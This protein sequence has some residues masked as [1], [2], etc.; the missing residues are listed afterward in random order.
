MLVLDDS[1]NSIN[2]NRKKKKLI[3][4]SFHQ[5]FGY[6]RP[7]F[8]FGLTNQNNL[9][10]CVL[11]SPMMMNNSF[12]IL[13]R[14]K[15]VWISEMINYEMKLV[16]RFQKEKKNQCLIKIVWNFSESIRI[17]RIFSGSFFFSNAIILQL[18]QRLLKFLDRI[19]GKNGMKS[20]IWNDYIISFQEIESNIS[21]ID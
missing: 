4:N 7:N 21:M 8:F 16:L 11:C 19:V 12:E 1:I 13:W 15:S 5:L 17:D 20:I 14:Q 6:Q 18:H 2:S 3:I 9:N 10:W